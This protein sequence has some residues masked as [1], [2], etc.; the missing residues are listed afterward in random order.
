[1]ALSATGASF[2]GSLANTA[3]NTIS[4][5]ITNKKNREFAADMAR[6]NIGAAKDAMATQNKYNVENAKNA[7]SYKMESLKNAGLNPALAYG[8]NATVPMASAVSGSGQAVSGQAPKIDMSGDFA[9]VFSSL[10]QD[11]VN[12]ATKGKLEAET[13]KTELENAD[14]RSYNKVLKDTLFNIYGAAGDGTSQVTLYNSDGTTFNQPIDEVNAGAIQALG[15]SQGLNSEMVKKHANEIKS[16]I[17]KTIVELQSKSPEYI[18][19]MV[20]K[21][22]ADYQL[23]K[24]STANTQANTAQTNQTTEIEGS[25][26]LKF[27]M[28]RACE[29]PSSLS[30]GE[31]IFLGVATVGA[32][33]G[34]HPEMILGGKPVTKT[35][36]IAEDKPVLGS[37]SAQAHI[38]KKGSSVTQSAT[39][40]GNTKGA[41]QPIKPSPKNNK[42]RIELKKQKKGKNTTTSFD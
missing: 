22:V 15:V 21:A 30:L 38:S 36:P 7:D 11:K 17:D 31:W 1:M 27:L 40:L 24:A 5:G 23:T 29:E 19:A 37:P 2:L 16:H 10:S 39:G 9:S 6:L 4:T 32:F 42:Q 13:E 26:N 35:K 3:A 18:D 33:L 28:S 34:G 8:G 41:T 20:N 25:T 14:K 12:E